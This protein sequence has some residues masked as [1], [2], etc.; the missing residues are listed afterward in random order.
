MDNENYDIIILG[1][2]LDIE[3]DSET[4]RYIQTNKKQETNIPGIHAA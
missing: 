3:F 1:S 2:G 4:M